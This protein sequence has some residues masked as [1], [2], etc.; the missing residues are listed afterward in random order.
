V[1]PLNV[2]RI[3]IKISGESLAG[4]GGI[5]NSLH[6]P[7]LL[8]ISEEIAQINK[9]G[10][11]IAIVVGG[12]NFYRG[13]SG[14]E[15]LGIDRCTSD[16]MGMMATVMNALALRSAI[17]IKKI[18][19]RVMSA[20]PLQAVAETYAQPKAMHHLNKGRVVV[21]AAG[22]GNPMFTTDTAAALRASEMNCDL[23]LKATK[24]KGVYDKDPEKHKDATLFKNIS[25][26]DIQEKKLKI[27]DEAAITL[28]KENKIPLGVF[29]IFEDN[30]LINVLNGT[31]EFTFVSI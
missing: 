20:L 27:M 10:Y 30:S 6:S 25:F 18:D 22:T 9:E 29:S 4:E 2:K 14:A 5:L 16:Y 12:G 26:K 17:Q 8:K 28:L 23:V 31:S 1:K 7:M 15:K 21:F 3:L 24:V 11:Q 19:C 13:V